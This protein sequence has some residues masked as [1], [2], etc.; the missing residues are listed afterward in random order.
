MA[1]HLPHTPLATAPQGDRVAVTEG[2]EDGLTVALACPHLRVLVA[3]SVGNIANVCLPLA[4]SSVY[5]CADND[6]PDTRAARALERAVTRWQSEGR[7][8]LLVRS[9]AGKDLNGIL[10]VRHERAASCSVCRAQ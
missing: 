4:I 7:R 8:V 6:A 1:R 10:Q 2:I 9:P 5:V 3:L